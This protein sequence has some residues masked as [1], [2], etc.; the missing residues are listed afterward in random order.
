MPNS[1]YHRSHGGGLCG[2]S[3]G[4]VDTGDP[5]REPSDMIVSATNAQGTVMV[6]G[7]PQRGR[8]KTRR[9]HAHNR[10]YKRE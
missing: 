1:V 5:N 10:I 7:G 9:G 2:T 3:C 8:T 6:P 4:M